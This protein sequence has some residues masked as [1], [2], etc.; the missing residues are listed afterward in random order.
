MAGIELGTNVYRIVMMTPERARLEI[1]SS[2]V[3]LVHVVPRHSILSLTYNEPA[4]QIDITLL[5]G[6]MIPITIPPK[7]TG[8]M[9]KL[10]K[11]FV[12]L[13]DMIG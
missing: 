11:L 1:H 10:K 13:S 9:A 7:S 4:A 6:T 5:N 2:I 3:D 12:E 8:A